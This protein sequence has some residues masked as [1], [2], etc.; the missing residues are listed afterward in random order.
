MRKCIIIYLLVVL[1]NFHASSI[2]DM[3]IAEI[4]IFCLNAFLFY[5]QGFVM[6]I[7][8]RILRKLC[9]L[10]LKHIILSI[11]LPWITL[12]VSGS[13]QTISSN[14]TILL[15]RYCN[16]LLI[17][18]VLTRWNIQTFCRWNKNVM[19]RLLINR[20]MEPQERIEIVFAL[21]F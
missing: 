16:L 19:T 18:F 13:I 11:Q 15:Y 8:A 3:L 5:P 2:G 14:Q 17:L 21:L 1:I 10:V 12:Y 20:S 6:K 9:G 4:I 7:S